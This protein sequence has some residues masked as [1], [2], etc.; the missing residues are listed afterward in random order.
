MGTKFKGKADKGKTTKK[1]SA[2]ARAAAASVPAEPRG[3]EFDPG[4]YTVRLKECHESDNGSFGFTFVGA[5]DD[6]EIGERIQWFSTKGKSAHVSGPRI[7]SLCMSL[8]GIP[9]ADVDEYNEFDPNGE[10]VDAILRF[11]L[12]AAAEYM[13]A[14]GVAESVEDAREALDE[15]T[16][17]I[18]VSKGGEKDDGGF[19]R[20]ATFKPA[21]DASD[22][23]DEDED[24]DED[25]DDAPKAKASKKAKATPAKV[26]K[27]KPVE[28]ED[29]D[30]EDED[31][32]SEDED[33][34]ESRPAKK[35]K[36]KAKARR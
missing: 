17:I 13:A 4:E 6:E 14:K 2:F 25:E 21:A 16:V 36:A 18:K 33:E 28:G 8:L 12:D 5:G 29:D 22:S 1:A 15:A 3:D 34:P 19:F 11:E 31:D 24:E 7:K 35:A 32:D 20:N 30:S 9:A 10:F 27:R 26:S 23:D